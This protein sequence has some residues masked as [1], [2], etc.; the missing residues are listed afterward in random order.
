V[1]VMGGEYEKEINDICGSSHDV[2]D[3]HCTWHKLLRNR[4]Q[5]NKNVG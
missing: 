4:K 5:R 1:R 3:E 2:S